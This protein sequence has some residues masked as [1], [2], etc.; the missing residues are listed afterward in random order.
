MSQTETGK[1]LEDDLKVAIKIQM[2]N[3]MEWLG[4]RE[5]PNLALMAGAAIGYKTAL[6]DVQ[7][8]ITSNKLGGRGKCRYCGKEYNNVAYHEAHEC[9]ESGATDDKREEGA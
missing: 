4:F 2:F 3:I 6:K 9:K 5:D 8:G 1:I 7:K